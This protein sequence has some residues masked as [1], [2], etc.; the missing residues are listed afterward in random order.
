MGGFDLDQF[1]TSLRDAAK[2]GEA[3]RRVRDLMLEAFRDPDAVAAAMTGFSGEE[4][5]LFED[6]SLSVWYVG[7]DARKHVP[8]HDHLVDATI[9]VYRGEEINHFYLVDDSGLVRKTSKHM[10]AGDVI[11]LRPDTIHSVETADSD[12]SY[13][14]HVYLGPLSTISRSLYDWDSGEPIP[15]DDDNYARLERESVR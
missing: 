6:E 12:W 9:G 2:Q 5:I 10:S 14:I 3:P 13:G 1:V 4:E 7:F 11:S 8:P 15:F